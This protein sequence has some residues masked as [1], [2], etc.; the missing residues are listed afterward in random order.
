MSFRGRETD[1]VGEV[2]DAVLERDGMARDGGV[3][4]DSSLL[5]FTDPARCTFGH[6]V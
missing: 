1:R 5:L 2:P 3:A 6:L 4:T